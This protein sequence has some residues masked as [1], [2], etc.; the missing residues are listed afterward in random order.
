MI[1]FEEIVQEEEYKER[2]IKFFRLPIRV[3][4]SLDKFKDY[5]EFL[6]LTNPSKYEMIVSYTEADFDC[7]VER[8]G[9]N[10][11]DFTMEY[12]IEPLIEEISAT[13]A[14]KNFV[15][16]DY[17][18]TLGDYSGATNIHQFY[19]EENDG[20]LFLS[21][22]LESAN[23]QSLQKVTGIKESYEELISKLTDNKI[24]PVSKVFRTKVTSLLNAKKIMDYNKH[25]LNTEKDNIMNVIKESTGV[26]IK[27]KEPFAF[28]ADEFL[29]ELNKEEFNALS[30]LDLSILE[31]EIFNSTGVKVHLNTFELKWLSLNKAC[32]KIYKDSFEILNI[33]KDIL[34]M[35]KKKMNGIELKEIDFEG[36]KYKDGQDALIEKID[37]LLDQQKQAASQTLYIRLVTQVDITETRA[38]ES[39]SLIVLEIE[40][41]SR[42]HND[43]STLTG[44]DRQIAVIPFII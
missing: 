8:Q 37:K 30:D 6:K 19:K 17:S 7:E 44:I 43:I 10:K 12:I 1:K 13:D 39:A 38:E 11:P 9:T 29:M 22:D 28:Y 35:I 15:E 25:L 14:W 26:E 2:V 16:E 40:F 20:K 18:D 5:M 42:I 31:E 21:V 41:R 24:P 23:W 33:S 32:M 34:L 36:V 4:V 3:S 27:S